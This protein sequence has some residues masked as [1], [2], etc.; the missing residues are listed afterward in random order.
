MIALRGVSVRALVSIAAAVSSIA[1]SGC[2]SDE[3]AA[4]KDP[5]RPA[6]DVAAAP[7][8]AGEDEPHGDGVEIPASERTAIRRVI[9]LQ[10]EALRR[11]DGATAFSFAAPT[12][13]EL[14]GTPE[15][16]LAMVRERYAPLYRP[17][18]VHFGSITLIA[19]EVTQE[20]FVVAGD[21][22]PTTALYLMDRQANGEWKIL[23]CVLAPSNK[24]ET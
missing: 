14:F 3:S 24:T 21:G 13:R 18:S 5:P 1:L 12:I 10:I 9:G 2:S 17:R 15:V 19:G 22:V 7:G 8:A 23:G 16:F 11:D 4:T 6:W 20:V